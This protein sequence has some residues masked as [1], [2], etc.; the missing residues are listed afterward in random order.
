MENKHPKAVLTD[1][2]GA[3]REAIKHVFPTRLIGYVPGI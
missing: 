2:D 1:G 3:M